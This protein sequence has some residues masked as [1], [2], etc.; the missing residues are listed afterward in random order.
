[1]KYTLRPILSVS[2]LT[3]A[4]FGLN[5]PPPSP[6]TDSLAPKVGKP[7]TIIK[8][9]GK[10][11]DKGHV[12]EVYLTDHRFDM[13]VKVLEQTGS[14]IT[15]R[16]PPFVKPGRLQLLFLTG[17]SN[18][19]YLEQPFY[20]QIDSDEDTSPPIEISKNAKPT[21]EVAAAGKQIP[22]PAAG[23]PSAAVIAAA[24]GQ[25]LPQRT[26]ETPKVQP[27]PEE[28]KQAKVMEAPVE[29][30]SVNP[31]PIEPPQV[32]VSLAPL[33]IVAAVL[34]S[35]TTPMPVVDS[36]QAPAILVRRSRVAY[37][38]AAL[39]SRIE[40]PVEL[41]AV[42]RV[43][44]RVKE[45]R[46]VKGHPSLAWAAVTSVRD[47][48]YEPARLHGKPVESEVPVTLNFKRPE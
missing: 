38:T 29:T 39:S 15:I 36:G 20:I 4:A 3:F 7:G 40:G 19:V 14:Q 1:M 43:D 32:A 33:P 35:A 47:W 9:K 34:P 8:I 22:V 12:D 30:V 25:I 21:V 27:K 45:V 41:I 44:G 48:V 13:S 42:V 17:G 2:I 26:I 10:A 16:I 37:P 46:V 23:S 31:P 5:Q 24:T 11:L 28:S 6:Q 18:P